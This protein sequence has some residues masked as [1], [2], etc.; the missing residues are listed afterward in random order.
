MVAGQ[1]VPVSPKMA[2]GHGSTRAAVPTN[3]GRGG[4]TALG[5][6]L[7]R[8]VVDDSTTQEALWI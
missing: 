7:E 4:V 6:Y 8:R 1:L 3:G 2:R 5:V